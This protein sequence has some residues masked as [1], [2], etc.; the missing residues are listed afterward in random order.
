MLTSAEPVV[1]AWSG[2]KDSALALHRLR[3]AREY[4]VVGLLTTVT[5]EHDRISM[6]GVRRA[7]LERQ[8]AELELPLRTVEIRAGTDNRGYE[9]AMGEALASF[10]GDGIRSVAFGDLFLREVREY[11][12][13]MLAGVGMCAIFP[14]W[15][16]PTPEV[17]RAFMELGFRA[18]LTCVDATQLDPAFTGRDYDAAL[19]RDLPP[20]VDPCGEN[21]EFHT[22]VH[23]GPIFRSAIPVRRGEQ[24][25]RE[26]RFH[27]QDLLP[28]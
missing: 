2:G 9:R 24:V 3:A 28:G 25:V 16:E 17:A 27:F 13:R 14:L 15:E 20:S 6:H 11:R 4:E 21:G 19:L 26:E 7:L 22:F 23:A 1:V 12:E 5:A 10:R 8:A 18:I